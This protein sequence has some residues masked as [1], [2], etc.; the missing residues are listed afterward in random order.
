MKQALALLALVAGSAAIKTCVQEDPT[1]PTLVKSPLPHT[2]INP[3]QLPTSFDWRNKDGKNYVTVS[4]NQHI[5][6]Y[7]GSCWAMATTSALSDRIRIQRTG[8]WPDIEV[9][10]Q[11]IVY[12]VPGGCNGGDPTAAYDYMTSTGIPSETCQNYV[13][14]GTGN[15]CTPIHTCQNCAPS[16][17][18][19][20]VSNFTRFFVEEH[21]GVSGEQQMMAEIYARG[22]IACG[23]DATPLESW[24]GH[25]GVFVGPSDAM[26]INHEISVVGWGTDADGQKYWVVRNSWG[27]YWGDNGFVYIQRGTNNI[28]IETN[29]DWAV[30]KVVPF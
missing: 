17:G 10:P 28:A 21:G 12:C 8:K 26:N 11:V 6:Q 4:R 20:A 9:S 2:Y 27:T 22:P 30:P 1:V 23:V 3:E 14:L 18:C 13:A 15:E 16:K 7:C 24:T 5:P 29:C 19:W 25:S